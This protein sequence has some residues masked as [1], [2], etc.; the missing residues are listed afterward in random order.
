VTKERDELRRDKERLDAVD[1]ECW[2]LIPEP[3]GYGSHYWVIKR[4]NDEVICVNGSESVRE[5]IDAAM[6]EEQS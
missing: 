6:K 3:D 1:R 4:N 2:H 5:A